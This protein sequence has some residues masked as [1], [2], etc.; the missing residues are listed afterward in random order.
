VTDT[1]SD[2]PAIEH[3]GIIGDLHTAALVATN[4][5][6][7]W[8][9]F[10]R[11]DS[12]SVFASLVDAHKG[13]HFR[14]CASS[15]SAV[16]RQLY[17]PDT[18]V[19][20]TRF[21]APE[22][23]GEIHDCM[24]I[25][26]DA[27]GERAKTHKLIRTVKTVRGTMPFQLECRPA[28]D[29]ARAPHTA[30]PCPDGVLFTAAGAHAARL[31]LLGSVPLQ[32]EAGAA[33]AS[34]ALEQG[35]SAVFELR[36]LTDGEAETGLDSP[37]EILAATE[38]TIDYWQRWLR[39]STY[40]GRWREVVNRSALT[41][42]LL[43]YAPTGAIIASPT[44]GLPEEIGGERNWDYRYTWLRDGAFTLYALMRIGFM[45]EAARFMDWLSARCE[46]AG[47]TGAL[48]V[49]Y[50]IDGRHNLDETV[51][52]HLEGYRGSRPVRL[53]NGAYR[54]LQLD[55]YGE[56]MDAVYLYDKYGSPISYELWKHLSRLLDNLC[57]TWQQ[58]DEG[59]WEV[60]GGRHHF[61]YSKM[62]CWVA[63]DRALRMADKRGLP[64]PRTRWR[65]A[66]SQI[67]EDVMQRGWN[68]ELKSFVQYY[69][70]DALDAANLLMPMVKFLSPTE[71]RMLQTLARTREALV[72]D[73]L[74][75]RY[76]PE[77]AAA[78]G[79]MGREGTFSMCTYWLVEALSRSGDVREARLT[80][81][82]MLTYAN[83]LELYSEE[84]GPSGE[85]LGNFPQAFT[86]LALISAAYNLDRLLDRADRG[87]LASESE[88]RMAE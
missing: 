18:N 67:Y 6:I 8:L 2:Y 30:T 13:G 23:V 44:M 11:F 27:Y 28:F 64:A 83:H 84:I 78:D 3:H 20:I 82:K 69:G 16:C 25:E 86:H 60:R 55:I 71:P 87:Q 12:P 85:S 58:P 26:T 73:S 31:A 80:F 48:Q 15:S 45:D 61:V 21:Q 24:P 59:I 41:L 29:Y 47:E 7:D 50:G 51:L 56:V 32:I 79:L 72:S 57:T 37:D 34:F 52:D 54:Q 22:G 53:G 42:K 14:I 81:E 68:P 9:C 19:L 46:E 74:V 5:C 76:A 10:P 38:R 40:R 43:T 70:G 62:M 49:M 36:Y 39:R 4:G 33:R 63:F 35:Q 66:Q 1:D 65:E 88:R 75:Y 17:V 77:R